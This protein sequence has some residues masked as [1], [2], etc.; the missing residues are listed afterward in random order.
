MNQYKT[1][2]C[3]LGGGIV[4]LSLANQVLERFPY[5]KILIIEKELLVGMHTSGRNSGVLHAGLYYDHTSLKAKVCVSGAKRLREW[6]EAEK[7]P[8]LACGKVITP[9]NPRLDSQLD[10]LFSRGKENGAKVEMIDE[11]QF[12]S[13]IPDGFTSTGRAIWSPNTCVVKPSMVMDHLHQQLVYR[14]VKFKYGKYVKECNLVKDEIT[15]SNGLRVGYE[16]LFNCS[17]LQSD[18]VAKQF[19]LAQQYTMLPFRGTYWQLKKDA[20]FKFERNLYPVPDL[21]VPFLGVHITPSIDGVVYLGPTAIPA[22]GR[23][24]YHGIT[25]IETNV[26]VDFAR[27]MT[28]QFVCDKRIRKY[29][30]EQAFQWLPRNFISAAKSIVP[31]LELEHIE[32]SSKVGIRPQLYD[33]ENKKLVDDFVMINKK[34]STHVVNAISPAFTA[35]FSL[36]DYI[37]DK[38]I[39]I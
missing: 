10:L 18:R 32:P 30:F 38:S 3:I 4:G 11:Q 34:K 36:A 26:I 16:H 22:F 23:E 13:L 5:L 27:H 39:D 24:N 15:L 37:L 17:G 33:M 12:H 2:I 7:L 9:Q 29:V 14:G 31:K 25:G 8:V 28:A 20:P 1:D 35:S 21:D 19:G 6:C